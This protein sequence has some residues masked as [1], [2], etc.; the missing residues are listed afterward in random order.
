VTAGG[1]VAGFV[2]TV[3][4]VVGTDAGIPPV[5]NT[6]SGLGPLGIGAQK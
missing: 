1:V 4:G 5:G 3:T 2:G 6:K